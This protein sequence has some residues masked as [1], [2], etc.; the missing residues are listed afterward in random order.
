MKFLKLFT[1]LFIFLVA[2]TIAS[3]QSIEEL[4]TN[5][6]EAKQGND[7][8]AMARGWYKLG[9]FYDRQQQVQKSNKAFL[10]ALYLANSI[11]SSKAIASIANYLASNYSI[12]GQSDS[13]IYYYEMALKA[14]IEH[15]D[16]TRI[17]VVLMNLGDSYANIG[18]YLKAANYA[19]SAIRIK[20]QIK[21]STNLAYYYQKVGEVYKSAGEKDKWEE[22]VKKAYKLISNANYTSVQAN[23][24]IYN[25]LGGIAEYHGNLDQALLYY[26]TLISIGKMN[27]Y[28]H[29]IGIALANSATIYKLKGELDKALQTALQARKFK[30]DKGYQEIYDN[31]SLAELFL[32]KGDSNE[33]LKYAQS[34]I[35]NKVINNNPEEK[36]RAFKI[37]YQAEKSKNNFE[38]A[39]R[40]NERF[41]QLSDSIRDKEIRTKILDL[42]IG[43]QTKKKEQQ[44]ELLTT[45]NELKNQRMRVGIILLA[46][47]IIVIFMILYILQIRRK[48]AKLVQND[49]R[50]QVLRSQ[51]NPH[52]IFNVLG[53]IQNFMMANDSKRAA[54]Y[55]SKFASLT[56]ATLEYS[57]EESIS[58]SDEI[59]M[60]RNYMEL[61]QMRKP[62]I[63]DFEIEYDE[64]LEV[65]FIQVPPMMIQPFIEN[66]IKHGFKNID[67]AGK[68]RLTVTDKV[69]YIEVGIQDNGVGIQ[70]KNGSNKQHR[71]MAM[72]IFEKRRK[73]I[74]H[75][76]NKD[77]KF[78]VL[79]LNDIS[80][81]LSGTK[82]ILTI[83]VL[84]ND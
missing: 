56:R 12:G 78:E 25:D 83:P 24:G 15:G 58:L 73:L 32:E 61:E 65:D 1:T 67:Y 54:G 53:S 14:S 52:F 26:D 49:L 10:K 37:L 22:Y 66:A 74:Q 70:H 5:I 59:A 9:V 64:E 30:T 29:A 21:D 27:D 42:E 48:Q 71:S 84:N 31:N 16:S 55:L 43:Y 6:T 68:L 72:D 46:V 38:K 51:M 69:E 39:L 80:A 4:Q 8:L 3:S 11:K 79:K 23:S 7:T 75:K 34:A 47:L 40:W 45:E 62:G 17:P 44:I 57:S 50:Q 18:E 13:A 35:D 63:F 20:E 36:M 2:S 41:K 76:F 60:L 82:I 28:P 81:N 19:I 77:F 33:A